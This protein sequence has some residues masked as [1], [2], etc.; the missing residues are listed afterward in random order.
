MGQAREIDLSPQLPH[1][2]NRSDD[3][4]TYVSVIV[5]AVKTK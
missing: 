4:K 1:L 3:D 2:Q 5:E